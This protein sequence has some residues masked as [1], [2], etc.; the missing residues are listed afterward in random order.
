MTMKRLLF[1]LALLSFAIPSGAA[2]REVT[3]H[4]KSLEGNLLGEPADQKIAV[5][6]PPSYDTSTKRY[7]VVYLLHGIADTYAVWTDTWKIPAMLDTLMKSGAAREMIV[8]MPNGITKALGS[9]YANSPVAGR[10]EDYISAELVSYVDK[11]FRTLARPESRGVVG[12]SMG[13]F[14]AIRM[15]MHHPDV[16]Q[17]VY[18]MSPCCLDFAEDIGWGNPAWARVLAFKSLDDANKA[19]QQGEF[20]PMAIIA[21]S[22]VITPNPSKPLLADFPIRSSHGELL[23]SDP[24]YTI[25]RDFFPVAEA[26]SRRENLRKLKAFALDYGTSDQFAHIPVATR[27]LAD[28]LQELR[29]PFTLSVY[30]GDHREHVVERLRGIV[31]PFFSAN[32]KF[33]D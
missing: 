23:P 17:A 18:A 26:E 21:F 33:E 15:G 24:T 30:D 32:L 6:L 11:N 12:H 19:L 16:Y 7:P 2:V 20:Y 31:F 25:W 8:V 13:G 5:Y 4:A 1:V 10:W 27:R 3:I 14:G 22:Q 28:R 29:V 9:F